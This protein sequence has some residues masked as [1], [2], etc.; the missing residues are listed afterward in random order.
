LKVGLRLTEGTDQNLT[1]CG[2][3]VVSLEI[4][5]R[6][7]TASNGADILGSGLKDA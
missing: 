4:K 3:C 5:T 2:D 6:R 1:G 7:I